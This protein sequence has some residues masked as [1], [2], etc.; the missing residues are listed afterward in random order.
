MGFAATEAFT[1]L[2]RAARPELPTTQA[3]WRG[4][5]RFSGVEGIFVREVMEF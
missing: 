5:A 1:A 2:L 3:R 4:S